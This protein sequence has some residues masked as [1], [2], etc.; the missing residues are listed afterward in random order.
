MVETSI[1]V[2]I[3]E[4]QVDQPRGSSSEGIL[5]ARTLR[6]GFKLQAKKATRVQLI[7]SVYR[8]KSPD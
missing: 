3:N 1:N 8:E 5:R 2:L 7:L 4:D 6:K